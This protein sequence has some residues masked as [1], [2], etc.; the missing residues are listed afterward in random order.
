[1]LHLLTTA[2]QTERERLIEITHRKNDIKE[3]YLKQQ[4]HGQQAAIILQL[5]Y[6]ERIWRQLQIKEKRKERKK[7]TGRL[8][9]DDMPRLLPDDAFVAAVIEHE[10]AKRAKAVQKERAK[11]VRETHRLEVKAW[12]AAEAERKRRNK[13]IIER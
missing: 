4:L 5:V 13:E 12:Q 1:M 11:A 10:E 3:A 6:C 9:C 8:I 2:P 7:G